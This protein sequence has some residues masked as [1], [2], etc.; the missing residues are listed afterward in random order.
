MFRKCKQCT[1]RMGVC[2][3]SWGCFQQREYGILQVSEN[4]ALTGQLP[5]Q[6]LQ[7]SQEKSTS[8]FLSQLCSL[9]KQ[10]RFYYPPEGFVRQEGKI[11]ASIL[12]QVKQMTFQDITSV[13]LYGHAILHKCFN[14][15]RDIQ[16]LTQNCVFFFKRKPSSSV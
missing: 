9:I 11:S 12:R 1:F 7:K 13:H 10:G 6:C 3:N 2:F 4:T 5:L 14:K 15:L 16:S 8:V